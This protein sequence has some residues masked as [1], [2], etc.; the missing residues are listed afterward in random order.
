LQGDASSVFERIQTQGEGN[1]NARFVAGRSRIGNGAVALSNDNGFVSQTFL[2]QAFG[3][4]PFG[5]GFDQEAV[6]VVAHVH[7]RVCVLT[8]IAVVVVVVVVVVVFGNC[9]DNSVGA[10]PAG[11]VK[12]FDDNTDTASRIENDTRPWPFH[13]APPPP[14]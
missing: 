13:V 4:L 11:R 5:V 10:L 9:V 3:S 14:P 8:S 12:M 2:G 6:L 7:V 1:G